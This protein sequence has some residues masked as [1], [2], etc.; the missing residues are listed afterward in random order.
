MKAISKRRLSF[1][2]VSGAIITILIFPGGLGLASPVTNGRTGLL[3]PLYTPA[4]TAS[5]STLIQVKGSYPSVP[6][7]AIINPKSGPGSSS[8]STFVTGIQGLQAAGIDVVGYI[9]TN[10]TSTNISTVENDTM[11]YRNWYHVNG[12]FFDDM[13]NNPTQVSYYS[14]VSNY[15]HSL[16]LALTIGNPGTSVP[17]SFIGTMNILNIYENSVDPSVSTISSAA[18]GYDRD[19]FAMIA[20]DVD[21]PTQSYLESVAPYVSYVYFT[22]ETGS[23]PFAGLT[24]YLNTLASE[25]SSIDGP[26]TSINNLAGA[27]TLG[28]NDSSL[29]FNTGVSHITVSL[30]L[31]HA[32]TWTATQTFSPL[33]TFS[34][35]SSTPSVTPSIW[36][37]S[38]GALH[39]DT[40]AGTW[41]YA[42]TIHGL[43]IDDQGGYIR[44]TEG[45]SLGSPGSGL[46]TTTPPLGLSI[47][48]HLTDSEPILQLGTGGIEFGAGGSSALS[49]R[50]DLCGTSICFDATSSFSPAVFKLSTTG[51]GNTQGFQSVIAQ[52]LT[53]GGTTTT[54]SLPVPEPDT[55]YA[56]SCTTNANLGSVWITGKATNQFVINTGTAA[57]PSSTADCIITHQ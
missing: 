19:N 22:E 44:N 37:D 33:I 43:G 27:L 50:I 31:G 46:S 28:N 34:D 14:T 26:D 45:I 30:N 13:S 7:I 36:A 1:L 15:A 52:V 41:I 35:Q 20:Y 5:W 2:L 24:S 11:N 42:T 12:T 4:G 56:V 39:L 29:T 16:G 23:N 8:D 49:F 55:A 47:Y 18:M 6:I 38:N 9:S 51:I 3:V 25:L 54:V 53:N 17:A 32:N 40:T 57:G 48:T 10:Y 21:A